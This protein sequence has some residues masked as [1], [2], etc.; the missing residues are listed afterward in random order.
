MT[1][2]LSG[3]GGTVARGTPAAV[4]DPPPTDAE[5][6]ART[7]AGEAAAWDELVSRYERLVYSVGLR[8]GL[9]ESEA[10]D[11]LETTFLALLDSTQDGARVRVRLASWLVTM[12]RQEIGRVQRGRAH[13]QVH[14]R[15]SASVA[16]A[17]PDARRQEAAGACDWERVA[18][19]HQALAHLPHRQ[20]ML[21]MDAYF[22]HARPTQ[23]EP[24]RQSSQ[25]DDAID[26]ERSRA[27]DRLRLKLAEENDS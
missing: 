3:T 20:R 13:H 6:V 4:D 2:L 24:P 9:N 1:G 22:D 26:H 16:H 7:A 15:S 21:V 12:A 18:T 8:E 5:L 10:A 14:S 27:L 23:A 19:V 25:T 11:A 17:V